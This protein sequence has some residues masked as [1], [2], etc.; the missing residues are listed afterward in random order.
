MSDFEKQLDEAYQKKVIGTLE[1]KVVATAILIDSQLILN[2][3]VDTGR[4]RANWLPSIDAPDLSIVPPS[5]TGAPNS[6]QRDADIQS[7]L[8][9]FNFKNTIYISNN[10]PYIKRLNDGH[11]QQAPA[12]F[13]ENI[14]SVAKGSVL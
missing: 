12:G 9:R 13:V 2:T 3:P 1:K 5:S 11:S 14:I 10:L 6:V 8:T 7:E 4:A